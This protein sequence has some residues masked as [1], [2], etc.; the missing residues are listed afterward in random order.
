MNYKAST[1]LVKSNQLAIKIANVRLFFL[2]F[3]FV[4]IILLLNFYQLKAKDV[5]TVLE[6]QTVVNLDRSALELLVTGNAVTREDLCVI[7]GKDLDTG[8]S[9]N[10]NNHATC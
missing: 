2:Y 5:K 9:K 7:C 10:R 1:Y 4:A 6:T 3:S 8:V